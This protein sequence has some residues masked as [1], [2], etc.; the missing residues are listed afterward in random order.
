MPGTD[1]YNQNVVNYALYSHFRRGSILGSLLFLYH[2]IVGSYLYPLKNI[3]LC[4]SFSLILCGKL[5]PAFLLS[6]SVAAL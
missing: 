1:I 5:P 6:V 3:S 4:R 2:Q